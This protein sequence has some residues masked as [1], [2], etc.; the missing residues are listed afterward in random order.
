MSRQDRQTA[1]LARGNAPEF[2]IDG[3][4]IPARPLSPGLYVVATPIGNLG[5][6]TVRALETLA[7]ADMIVC[8]DT[9]VTGVLTSYFGISG[10]LF[11]YND[12]NAARQRPKILAALEEEKSVALVSDAGTPLV[13]DPGYRLVNEALEA[14][15]TIV[16]IP[17]ASSVLAALVASGLP[18]DAFLFA[19]FLPPKKAARRKR[20]S[21]LSSTPATLIFFESPRR[22][23][24]CLAD[25][26]DVLGGDRQSAIAREL[27]KLFETV[28]RGSLGDL[29]GQYE[30]EPA[31]KGEIVILVGPPNQHPAAPEDIDALLIELLA[32]HPVREA[33]AE[34]AAKTG[35]GRRDLYQRALALKKDAEDGA[36]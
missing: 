32:S 3:R 4:P 34:A 8:E 17:G 18:S 2:S 23:A 20:L 35:L 7:A 15:H 6:I 30:N 13:S 21:A 36:E 1:N 27:T 12:Y 11:A 31:P 29:S 16:P 25:M 14:G 19:G 9:R 10:R 22:L 5:D 33:A 28:R 24:A 26:A